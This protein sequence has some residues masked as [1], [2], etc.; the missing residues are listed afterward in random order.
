MGEV[1]EAVSEQGHSIKAMTQASEELHGEIKAARLAK[2]SA[3]AKAAEDAAEEEKQRK[4]DQADFRKRL[5]TLATSPIGLAVVFAL[6][7]ALNIWKSDADKQEALE[8][9][10][11]IATVEAGE[12]PTEPPL[13]PPE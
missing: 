9:F 8:A 2:A 10:K 1:K 6:L 3:D 12:L 13:E 11:A 5:Q 7:S 4:K